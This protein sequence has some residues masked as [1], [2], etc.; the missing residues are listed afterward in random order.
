[1][2]S[3]SRPIVT[4]VHLRELSPAPAPIAVFERLRGLA[5]PWLLDSALSGSRL[6]RFSFA[7]ADPYLVV[8]SSAAC[9]QSRLEL[10]RNARPD[11]DP[12]CASSEGDPFELVRKLLPPQPK[13][14]D[15]A[16][17]PLPPLIGGA[18][19]YFGYELASRIEP[20]HF[21]G[22]DD[23]GLPDLALVFVDRLVAF[24]LA[25]CCAHAIGLGFATGA[26]E[27]SLRARQ[28]AESIADAVAGCARASPGDGLEAAPRRVA[29]APSGLEACF[30]EARYAAAVRRIGGQISAGN[31][32]QANLTQRMRVPFE[33][34][35]SW[36]LYRTLRRLNPAPFGA[37][38]ELPEAAILGSSPE[39]F[40]RLDP[41]GAVESRPIKGTRP[42]GSTPAADRRLERELFTSEK[43]RAENLMIVDLVRN[44]L[45]RV[46]ATGSIAVPE[47]R[48]IEAYAGVFQMVSTVTGR[49]R[50]NLDAIDLLRAC[51]PPGS[52]TGAPKIAAIRLLDEIEPVRRGV[53]SGALGYLDVRGGLDLSVVIRTLIVRHGYAY[54]HAGGGIVSDS[55]PLAEY[56][57]SLDKARLLLEALAA[58]EA[59][60]SSASLDP[61]HDVANVW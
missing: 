32:Y 51:F 6:G 34:R 50:A 37:Y 57:E 24:D 18:V 54:L 53:Y 26:A 4:C 56:R 27:A 47:L 48:V 52:M 49:L 1:M 14:I 25:R 44:D 8:R 59:P 55:E 23:L 35:D 12:D 43:D 19:G 20:I 22:R 16:V 21:H 60:G 3:Q 2:S 10:L 36:R 15:G 41:D 13:R 11:L 31:V 28:A 46:C 17:A 40:L 33:A 5:Y 38:L 42:R 30:D 39:R 45:G 9:G 7:G 61:S 58:V 29:D